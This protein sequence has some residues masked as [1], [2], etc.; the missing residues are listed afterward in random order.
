MEKEILDFFAPL[1]FDIRQTRNGRFMDQKCTPDV[2]C[3]VCE[4]VME[5]TKSNSNISFTKNDIWHSEYA[6][7]LVTESFSKPDLSDEATNSEYDKFFA[8]PLKLL[9]SAQILNETKSGNTNYYTI[10]NRNM[11]EY[12]SLR[13]RNA[14]NF[15]DEYLTKTMTDSDMMIWFE[16]FFDVQDKNSLEDLRNN[17]ETFYH[18]YTNIKGQYE[19]SRIFNKIINILAFKRKRKGT[20]GGSV[21]KTVLTIDEVRYN[22][23]N[24][25]DMNKDKS[26]PRQQYAKEFEDKLDTNAGFYK[27]SVQKA[28]DFVRRLH[29]YSEIHRFKEYPAK[30][31]HH[32]FMASEF[33]EIADYPE[34]IICITPNQHFNRAHPDNKTSIVDSDYQLI[35][36]ISK[37]DS[38]EIN[39]RSGKDDYSLADFAHVLNTGFDTDIFN[40]QMGYEEIK[41]QIVKNSYE[42]K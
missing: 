29:E 38:I 32:I 33:P 27:Y 4:C 14:L 1:N 12:I 20:V 7:N 13:E 39:Y 5:Y 26:M 24:W 11:L 42:K 31:A 37:L 9:A 25:R 22:R 15:L 41:H 35:C 3:A 30:Q 16:R 17:L 8:Q 34:N 10:A 2:V 36:L 28:K 40:A 18:S 23:I 21:S 6:N 19:P